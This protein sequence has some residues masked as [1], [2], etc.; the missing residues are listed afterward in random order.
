MSEEIAGGAQA[1][2]PDMSAPATT[3]MESNIRHTIE[4]RLVDTMSTPL[5]KELTIKAYLNVIE[6]RAIR[7]AY[8]TN[9]HSV[10]DG[11]GNSKFEIIEGR[12]VVSESE[13]ALIRAAVVSYDN[14]TEG[15][16]ERLLQADSREHKFVLE[17]C[18]EI[19]KDPK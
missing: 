8:S 15:I 17:R 9:V 4:G 2:Q 10:T 13:D 18:N 5:G 14:S 6:R 7:R 11:D 16:L 12:D 3:G 19:G 1:P